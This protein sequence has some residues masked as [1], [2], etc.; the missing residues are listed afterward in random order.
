MTL[1]PKKR[2]IMNREIKARL[3]RDEMEHI[4]RGAKLSPQNKL[5]YAY[6]MLRSHSLGE[7]A[8]AQQTRSEVLLSAIAVLRRAHPE[9]EPKYDKEYFGV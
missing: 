4:P 1:V 5:R 7:R 2:S 8:E 6:Q 3:I 9:A